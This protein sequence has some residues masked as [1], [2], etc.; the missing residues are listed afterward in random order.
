MDVDPI[1]SRF[2]TVS[3]IIEQHNP[4]HEGS[5]CDVVNGAADLRS[6]GIGDLL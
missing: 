1:S 6:V 3:E 2:D 4:V 5:F